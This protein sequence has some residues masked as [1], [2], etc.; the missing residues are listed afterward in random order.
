MGGQN[1]RPFDAFT[2]G[3]SQIYLDVLHMGGGGA[4]TLVLAQ[5]NQVYTELGCLG[6][7]PV[8]FAFAPCNPHLLMCPC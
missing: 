1:P 7:A 3:P 8:E 2:F 5:V 6:A 4:S